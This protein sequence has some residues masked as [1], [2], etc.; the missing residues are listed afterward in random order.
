MI[1]HHAR[2]HRLEPGTAHDV[3]EQEH[4]QTRGHQVHLDISEH[5]DPDTMIR[6]DSEV[7]TDGGLTWTYGGGFTQQGGPPLDK[8]GQPMTYC[9]VT[10]GHEPHPQQPPAAHRLVRGTITI[11]GAPVA[12]RVHVVGTTHAH[13][14]LDLV[15]KD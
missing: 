13:A 5:T 9:V 1:V 7:S 2:K 14:D 8:H 6:Y 11:V 12:T 3:P 15:P 10:F 4:R